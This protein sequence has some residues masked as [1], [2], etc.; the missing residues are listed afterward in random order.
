MNKTKYILASFLKVVKYLSPNTWG[1]SSFVVFNKY[2]D[3]AG[4]ESVNTYQNIQKH[5]NS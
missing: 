3:I 2:D 5:N 4:G 1:N